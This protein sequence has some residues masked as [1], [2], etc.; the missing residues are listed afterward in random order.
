MLRHRVVAPLALPIV[1]AVS[2]ALLPLGSSGAAPADASQR[3]A[4]THTGRAAGFH[5]EIVRTRH[6]IPHIT[7]DN[8]A[9]L[10]FGSGYA[11][12]ENSICTLADTLVTGRGER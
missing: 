6:G 9:D 7:A 4:A 2:A 8:F 3:P 12:A 5:A 11:A 1:L 10:G